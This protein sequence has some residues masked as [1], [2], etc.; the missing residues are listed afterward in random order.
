[1]WCRRPLPPP[2][3]VASLSLTET[4]LVAALSLVEVCWEVLIL[5]AVRVGVVRTIFESLVHFL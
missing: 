4:K 2:Q 1:M 5:T 3:A